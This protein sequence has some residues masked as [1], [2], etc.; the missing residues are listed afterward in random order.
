MKETFNLTY[1]GLFPLG[2][3]PSGKGMGIKMENAS[4]LK[5]HGDDIILKEGGTYE[6]MY[7][8]ISGSVAVYIRYGEKEEHLIG[9][10]SK[11]KCFG[12]TNVL[13]GQPSIYT[14]VAYEDVLLMRI[15]KDSLEEFIR[16]NPRNAIDI[17]QN[18]VHTN[19]L[20]Q[21]NIDLLLDDIY[22]KQDINKRRTEE[23]KD[24]IRSEE[25]RVGKE[26]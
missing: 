1:L 14:V 12:E 17:M 8:I 16:K 9:I 23:M 19:M 5:F 11:S 2:R 10:Y 26:C 22:E 4:M 7:K 21:K 20:M 24:K 18:M 15:T 6:E 13:S 25:R 3:S